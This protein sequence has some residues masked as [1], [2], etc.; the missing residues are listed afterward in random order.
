VTIE[1]GMSAAKEPMVMKSFVIR[2]LLIHFGNR[3]NEFEQI[4]ERE[5]QF[6]QICLAKKNEPSCFSRII[7][8]V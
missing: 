4:R 7:K 3:E 8:V 1:K 2:L 6:H 5:N